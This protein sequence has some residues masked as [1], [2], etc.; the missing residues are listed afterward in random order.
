MYVQ[1]KR[2]LALRDHETPRKK[3]RKHDNVEWFKVMHETDEKAMCKRKEFVN[4]RGSLKV[5]TLATR[6]VC[7]Q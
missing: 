3:K 2:K 6:S 7:E 1:G 5:M 4:E